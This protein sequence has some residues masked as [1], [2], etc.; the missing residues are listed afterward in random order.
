MLKL[1][2]S[3]ILVL[4]FAFAFSCTDDTEDIKEPAVDAEVIL[5]DAAPIEPDAE[6]T[7]EDAE[8]EPEPDGEVVEPEPDAAE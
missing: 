2:T 6:A 4:V 1:L 8:V 5:T 7:T 3:L